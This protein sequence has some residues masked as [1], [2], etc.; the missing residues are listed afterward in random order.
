MTDDGLDFYETF[1]GDG[2]QPFKITGILVPTRAHAPPT[3]EFST[4]STGSQVDSLTW[5]FNGW[6]MAP[7]STLTIE[8]QAQLAPGVTEGQAIENS[9]GATSPTSGLV[10]AAGDKAVTDGPYGDGTWCTDTAKVITKAGA[11]FK[12]RKWVA[13]NK[14]LG[15]WNERS[16]EQVAVGAAS[17]PSATFNGRQYTAFPCVALLNPSATNV[18]G[19]DRA[20]GGNVGATGG[21]MS[22]RAMRDDLLVGLLFKAGSM[23]DHFW[24]PDATEGASVTAAAFLTTVPK[25]GALVAITPPGCGAAG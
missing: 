8:I 18:A 10:C 14:S 5:K 15:W 3:P 6:Q 19:T 4:T 24:V 21:A 2:G 11:A 17:C 20:R 25:I 22:D 23:P 13:G 16:Q 1:V 7:C 12:A 9:M